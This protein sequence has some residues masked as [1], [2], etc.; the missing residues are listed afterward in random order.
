MEQVVSLLQAASGDDED[1]FALAVAGSNHRVQS[2]LSAFGKVLERERATCKI[3]VR[4]RR[5]ELGSAEQFGRLQSRLATQHI[6][7]EDCTLTG[8]L[9][10][11]PQAHQFELHVGD[12]T[13]A[14][15]IDPSVPQ[16]MLVHYA[17]SDVTIQATKTTVATA[18]GTKVRLLM[19]H[20]A[21]REQLKGEV[22]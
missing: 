2:S 16:E 1:A 20:I 15:R 12:E 19:R 21:A 10:T 8:K 6:L 22:R 11:L 3:G 9:F 7:H 4:D 18:A 14:G 5:F 13:M 17:N